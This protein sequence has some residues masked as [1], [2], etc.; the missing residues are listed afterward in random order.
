MIKIETFPNAVRLIIR[1][2]NMRREQMKKYA[3]ILMASALVSSL[4]MQSTVSAEGTDTTV[5]EQEAEQANFLKVT[6]QIES[7]KEESTGHY[8][9]TVKSGNEEFGFYYND[10]TVILNNAGEKVELL[11]GSEITVYVDAHQ[12]MIMIYPPRYSPD[13][14]IV[15]SEKSGTVELQRFNEKYLNDKG[16]LVIHVTDKTVI[17][18]LDGKILAKDAIVDQD[19]LIFYNYVLESYP[20]Q[21]GPFKIV[22]LEKELSEID[23]AIAIANED[24]YDVNGV[25]M[26]PLRRV[27]EQLGFEVE[28][29]GNVAMV[30]NGRV[31]FTITLGAKHYGYNKALRYFEEAPALL[32]KN[33]TYVPYELLD[34]LKELKANK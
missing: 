16:D 19:V 18:N 15:Q 8:Y 23:K 2:H 12:S 13:V 34:Q 24:Y 32:E 17:S 21:T 28:S 29:K 33:K 7:L 25:K 9:A 6:G 5:V 20:A 31:T 26:I 14:V 4:F 11:K 3:S 1:K 30:S 27:A 22:V 10:K